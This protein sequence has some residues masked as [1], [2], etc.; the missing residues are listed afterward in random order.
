MR[1]LAILPLYPPNSM[2]GSWLSTHQVLRHVAQ[3]HEVRVG[4]TRS[5][6]T[7]YV[8]EG[9]SVETIRKDEHIAEAV[10]QADVLITHAGD[11][12]RAA[13]L[14]RIL[15]V[16][17]IR[18]VHG[19]ESELDTADLVVFNAEATRKAME[20]RY[21]CR[22]IV[23]YPPVDPV[24]YRVDQI[25]DHV[26]IVNC[27]EHK[28]IKTAWKAAEI[29]PH[30]RFLGVRGH[31]GYQISPRAGN[32]RVVPSTADI[33]KVF[34]QT[35]ILLMPSLF[36]TYGRVGVEAFASGIPVIA[37]P[38]P[39]LKES[40][41]Y[42]G[43]FVDRDDPEAWASEIERLHDPIAWNVASQKAKRRSA[44]LD[45]TDHLALFVHEMEALVQKVPA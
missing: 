26:T 27:T 13:N 34:R 18:M 19:Q 4:V 30:R 37:H 6:V 40:L 23:V 39:G 21:R 35:R 15:G 29:L 44:E 43:V 1:V 3:R 2:V 33:R 28:G 36:E 20:G 5:R 16:P 25:G 14:S 10:R 31:Y 42:A 12:G 38:T 17:H 24:E 8:H 11:N 41:G 45:P 32:F 7:P 9:V 22:S